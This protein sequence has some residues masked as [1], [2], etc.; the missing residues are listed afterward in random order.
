MHRTSWVRQVALV[1]AGASLVLGV[2]IGFWPVSANI[3]DGTSYS[4]GTGFVHSRNTWRADTEAIAGQRAAGVPAATPTSACPSSVY[5]DRDFA[6]ALLAL[7]ALTY[8]A[9]LASAAF[10]PAATPM[11]ARRSRARHASYASHR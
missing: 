6:Y 4:C 7:A 2:A 8:A 9:L 5:R 11:A 1:F 3:A 10:D